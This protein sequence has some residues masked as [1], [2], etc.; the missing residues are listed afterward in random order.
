MYESTFWYHLLQRTPISI[1]HLDPAPPPSGPLVTWGGGAVVRAVVQ[2]EREHGREEEQDDINDSEHPRDLEHGARLLHLEGP[3]V[4]AGVIVA[5]ELDA[6]RDGRADAVPALDEVHEDH[7]GDEAGEEGDVNEKD[8]DGVNVR[9][10]ELEEGDQAPGAGED[11]DDER[12][13]EPGRFGA[14]G[15]DVGVHEVSEHA[16]H[17]EE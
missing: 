8:N 7:R 6:D 2:L 15:L 12:E 10:V 4:A 14:V 5:A 11:R 9:A 13:E 1:G 17:R 16:H 3:G